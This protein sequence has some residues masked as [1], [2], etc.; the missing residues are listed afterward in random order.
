MRFSFFDFFLFFAAVAMPL[1]MPSTFHAPLGVLQ[2][3]AATLLLL[4]LARVHNLI[5]A[6]LV[7]V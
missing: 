2:Q 4:L 1:P 3:R 7:T 5:G 6:S